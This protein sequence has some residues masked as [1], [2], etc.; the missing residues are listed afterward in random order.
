[1]INVHAVSEHTFQTKH[2]S[3]ELHMVHKRYDGD[4]LLIIAVPF[5]NPTPPPNVAL[6]NAPDALLQTESL[7]AVKRNEQA[8]TAG[9]DLFPAPY[10]PPLWNQP[11][12]NPKLQPLLW[13]A[14][15]QP[16]DSTQIPTRPDAPM[17]LNAFL[18]NS[19]LFEYAGSMTSPPCMENAQWLVRTT[20]IMASDS[21]V[22]LFVNAL[23]ASNGGYGNYRKT[24]PLNGRQIRVFDAVRDEPPPD[25]PAPGWKANPLMDNATDALK[26]AK[27]ITKYVLDMEWRLTSTTARPTQPAPDLVNDAAVKAL[28]KTITDAANNAVASATKEISAAVAASAKDAAQEAVHSLVKPAR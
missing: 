13:K 4:G 22:N 26:F 18:V 15:P 9:A 12:F 17:D 23:Y 14:L 7:R 1:M 8:P 27:N 2:T 19:S 20:P 16:Y 11:A 28:T 24:M 25:N 10:V 3:L 6:A 21:Q 5:S